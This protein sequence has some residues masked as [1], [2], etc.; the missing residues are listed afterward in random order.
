MLGVI[1]HN[2]LVYLYNFKKM[3]LAAGCWQAY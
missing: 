1:E 2:L 3:H